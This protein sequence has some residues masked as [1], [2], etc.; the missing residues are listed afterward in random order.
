MKV[1][2]LVRLTRDPELK[3]TPQGIAVCNFDVA[4]NDGFGDKQESSFIR[5]VAFN[6]NAENINKLF[7]KGKLFLIKNGNLKQN[8]FETQDGQKKSNYQIIVNEWGFGGDGNKNST[9]NNDNMDVPPSEESIN[10]DDLP[11]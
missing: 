6:K 2:D 11:F 8:R 4:W 3:Y 7:S 1:F 5:C 9:V 10:L